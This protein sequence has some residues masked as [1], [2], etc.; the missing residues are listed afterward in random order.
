MRQPNRSLPSVSRPVEV[1]WP[2]IYNRAA[3]DVT[4]TL[5]LSISLNNL[6]PMVFN[7]PQLR[8]AMTEDGGLE[9]LIDIMSMV[10]RKDDP[11][12]THVRKVALQ[13]LTQFGIRG[14]ESIR[15][16]TVEAQII[17]VLITVLECFWRAMEH[18]IREAIEYGLQPPQAPRATAGCSRPFQTLTRR[19]AVT[20]GSISTPAE[21]LG[22]LQIRFPTNRSP[23]ARHSAITVNEALPA[24]RANVNDDNL[25]LESDR[26]RMDIDT[27]NNNEVED[28]GGLEDPMMDAEA[29][30]SPP[31]E[32][33]VAY[34]TS[35]GTDETQ[36]PSS[37]LLPTTSPATIVT[38]MD[39]DESSLQTDTPVS[40]RDS[41]LRTGDANPMIPSS[42]REGLNQLPVPPNAPLLPYAVPPHASHHSIEGSPQPRLPPTS[43]RRISALHGHNPTHDWRIPRSEDIV[44][45]LETLAYLSKY[46][47]L[48]AFF[49]STHFTP[50]LLHHWGTPEDAAK[51][52]NVFEIVER[53]TFTKYHPDTVCFWASIVMRHYS[54]KDEVVTR[55]QC[56]NLQCRQWET[57]EPGLKF[58][59]C[60]KC[61]YFASANYN[62]NI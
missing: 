45:C 40:D 38:T 1:L 8:Q 32:E 50:S 30:R 2:N 54:R 24:E 44:E 43:H 12:E 35:F 6:R 51:E 47:K 3:L 52:V 62:T 59:C 56:G 23:L 26:D 25:V 29:L 60:P 39:V 18:D 28:E 7:L 53:F 36:D 49:N 21:R 42:P 11:S 41:P 10:R 37:Q 48:R 55:R 4:S 9:A 15:L 33:D 31:P 27:P 16:R 13:C 61:K 14:P 19:R 57:D 46:P 5:P 58:I 17:P 34:S 22:G 20:I